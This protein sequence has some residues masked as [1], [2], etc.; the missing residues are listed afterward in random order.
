MLIIEPG[1]QFLISYKVN[2]PSD[3]ATYYVQSKV[4][5]AI[6]GALLNTVNLTDNGSKF[7]SKIWVAPSDGTQNGLQVYILTTVYTDAAFTTESPIYGTSLDNYIVRH[8]ASQNLGGFTRGL[9]NSDIEAIVS[10]L[11]EKTPKAEA[12]AKYDDSELHRRINGIE[13]IM[14]DG[15][16]RH[17]E[18]LKSSEENLKSEIVRTHESSVSEISQSIQ[19]QLK[20][21]NPRLDRLEER[22]D[23]RHMANI[24]HH[25][26]TH[27]SIKDLASDKSLHEKIEE[28]EKSSDSRHEE[29]KEKLSEPVVIKARREKEKKVE[30][31]QEPKPDNT[32]ERRMT[33]KKLISMS[34]E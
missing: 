26:E 13:T 8:L 28:H 4:Y 5:N 20:S 30:P 34:H 12:P 9:D 16:F 22:S 6:S 15:F 18:N 10:R 7:Y 25:E 27:S 11:F 3:P 2:N 31:E 29:V 32:E 19:E 17:G 21:I 14:N 1:S 33:V 24:H 23:E